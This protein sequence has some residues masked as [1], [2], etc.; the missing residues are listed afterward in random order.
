MRAFELFEASACK[1]GFQIYIDMDGVLV[2]FDKGVRDLLNN[3]SFKLGKKN[4]EQLWSAVS[5]MD[6]EDVKE[7]WASFDWA[8]GGKQLWNYVSK[9][10]AT[11]LSSPGNQSRDL[12]EAGKWEWIRRNMNPQP[13]KVI[14]E[15]DKWKYASNCNILI[16]DS[17]RKLVPWE[18]HGGPTIPYKAGRDNY[19]KVIKKLQTRF[20]FP[21]R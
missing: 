14:L 11:V 16:D 1:T 7:V 2:D 10:D 6:P 8:P 13:K 5:K 3:P 19:T 18:E 12:I 15:P 9:H 4:A 20:G 17:Q 21:R